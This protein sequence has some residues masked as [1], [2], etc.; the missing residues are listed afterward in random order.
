MLVLSRASLRL[1]K[2]TDFY[3]TSYPI[4]FY[5]T[6]RKNSK[7]YY[8]TPFL[9]SV[10]QDFRNETGFVCI[11]FALITHAARHACDLHTSQDRNFLNVIGQLIPTNQLLALTTNHKT[12]CWLRDTIKRDLTSLSALSTSSHC[13]LLEKKATDE[14]SNS[15]GSKPVLR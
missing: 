13:E 8:I 10:F 3:P 1:N 2:T 6:K 12:P 14:G 15:L 7:K 11:F 5:A 9:L 4:N